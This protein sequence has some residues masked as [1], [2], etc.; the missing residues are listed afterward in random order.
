M[1]VLRSIFRAFL[2]PILIYFVLLAH[3]VY[4]VGLKEAEP[5]DVH[6]W[7][8]NT[9]AEDKAAII[10]ARKPILREFMDFLGGKNAEFFKQHG[11]EDVDW[12]DAIERISGFNEVDGFARLAT[13]WIKDT[14]IEVFSENHAPHEIIM[15][16]K[17]KTTVSF[18]PS[19]P[20]SIRMR[21]HILLEPS[22][23]KI[24]AP[25]KVFRVFEEWGG[26]PLLNEKSVA[27]TIFGKLHSKLR[28]FHGYMIN[29]GIKYGIL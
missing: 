20:M 29:Q 22:T 14:E 5:L 27:P 21:T 3:V 7:P 6:K 13:R 11:T 12:E 10:A 26:N 15:D 28:K 24:G 19:L 1:G 2:G 9:K 4:Q 25:E 16:W 17:L 23:V 8:A 18:L